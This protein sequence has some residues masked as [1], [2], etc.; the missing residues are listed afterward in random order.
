MLQI[1]YYFMPGQTNVKAEIVV[2]I[3]LPDKVPSSNCTCYYNMLASNY[4][5][6]QPEKAKK[7]I[8][9]NP[10]PKITFIVLYVTIITTIKLQ[11][12]SYLN[13]FKEAVRLAYIMYS[14]FLNFKK[15]EQNSL[16][17][18]KNKFLLKLFFQKLHLKNSRSKKP[19][20]GTP[21]FRK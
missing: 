3:F 21:L 18:C 14:I 5:I 10:C 6:S 7:V 15:F 1:H 12:N 17:P 9:S 2:Q 16:I 8:K 11:D 20:H 4:K 13:C 19:P